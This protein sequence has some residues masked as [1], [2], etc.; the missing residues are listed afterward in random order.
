M[1]KKKN[2]DR[3]EALN[4]NDTKRVLVLSAKTLKFILLLLFIVFH[5]HITMTPSYHSTELCI[6][7]NE[8]L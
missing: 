5:R 8:E 7:N 2:Q 3:L 4:S 6:G 1:F